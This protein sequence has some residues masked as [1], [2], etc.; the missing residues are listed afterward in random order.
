MIKK[1]LIVEDEDDIFELLNAIFSNS[2]DYEVLWAKDGH[3]ALKI[4]QVE[5]PAIILLDVQL[6]G[7]SGYEVCR[8]IKSNPAL[9]NVRILMLSGMTQYQDCQKAQEAGADDYVTK[10]FS[11][12]T[13]LNKVEELLTC[14]GKG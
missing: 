5:N 4:A 6:P 11:S 8:L 9:S 10:P 3:E 1:I 14:N 13:L 7:L 2:V 12:Y